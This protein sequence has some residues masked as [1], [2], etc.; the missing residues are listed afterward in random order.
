VD[1]EDDDGKVDEDKSPEA[2]ASHHGGEV[3]R[4]GLKAFLVVSS[5]IVEESR[6]CGCGVVSGGVAVSPQ[7]EFRC[8]KTRR[9]ASQDMGRRCESVGDGNGEVRAMRDGRRYV[10]VG[11]DA[12]MSLR[13]E[14]PGSRRCSRL[15]KLSPPLSLASFT[16]DEG[17]AGRGKKQRQT[18]AQVEKIAGC[19][20]RVAIGFSGYASHEHRIVCR[21][22]RNETGRQ[23]QLRQVMR[24]VQD[25][26][27]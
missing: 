14:S 12:R 19:S 20:V 23:E 10:R 25:R 3:V 18:A 16:G 24:G 9:G 21:R 5:G 2:L 4:R 22:H 17:E 26:Q 11:D 1:E 8:S 6:W 13:K 27:A 7:R 15:V